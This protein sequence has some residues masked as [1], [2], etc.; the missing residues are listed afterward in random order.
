M[1]ERRQWQGQ[2]HLDGVLGPLLRGQL[3]YLVTALDPAA[4]P[5]DNYDVTLEDERGHDVLDGAGANRDAVNRLD[6]PEKPM[7]RGNRNAR[8]RPAAACSDILRSDNR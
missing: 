5:N 7:R 2:H 8:N 4:A 3:D 6:D 1:G